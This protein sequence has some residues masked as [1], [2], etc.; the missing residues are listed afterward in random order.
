MIRGVSRRHG[1]DPRTPAPRAVLLECFRAALDAVDARRC[2]RA[3]LAARPVSGTWHVV[4]VGKAAGAMA[5]G[6]ADVLGER[7]AGGIVVAPAGH[8]PGPLHAHAPHMHLVTS[9]HPVPD[10]RSL[11]AGEAVARF[12]TALPGHAPLLF[13]VSGGAS[14][15]LEWP[16]A[17]VTLDDLAQVNRWALASGAPITQ[18]NAIRRR[19]SSLKGGGLAA[20]A[21]RR[22]S[23]ALMISD[24]PRDEPRVIGSGLLHAPDPAETLATATLPLR[25]RAALERAGADDRR[26]TPP[27]VPTRMVATIRMA[28]AAAAAKAASHGYAPYRNRVR[29]TGYAAGL[30]TRWAARARRLPSRTLAIQGGESTVELPVQP[31]RGGRNQHLA[32]AAAIALEAR[33]IRGVWLLA[34]GTDGSD[35]TTADAGAIVDAGTCR[36][37]RDA[38][39][40]PHVSLAAADSG[41]FLEAAGDLLHTGATLT[42]VGDLVLVLKAGEGVA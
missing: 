28:C 26:T 4:A 30:G 37:G 1:S 10:E 17:G 13:L 32:L 14:A 31:G 27:R 9:S 12:V 21:G 15:L 40:D 42:N 35:G 6:A 38:G 24:V 8:F 11:A 33:D 22:R 5:L 25:V 29:M 23:L 36:R 34:A 19:L 20:M 2:V 16:R 18:V 41:S 3:S 7:L 39:Y